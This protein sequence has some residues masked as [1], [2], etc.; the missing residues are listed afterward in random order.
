M[1]KYE[2]TMF[3]PRTLM[4]DDSTPQ[5]GIGILKSFLLN[6]SKLFHRLAIVS[7]KHLMVCKLEKIS[8]TPP[9]I[10]QDLE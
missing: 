6:R 2:S 1:D 9:L 7:S 8:R 4:S 10:I 3:S 5:K